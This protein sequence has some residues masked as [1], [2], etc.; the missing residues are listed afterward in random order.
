MKGGPYM[1]AY[2]ST[3]RQDGCNHTIAVPLALLYSYHPMKS[4]WWVTPILELVP[5]DSDVDEAKNVTHEDR[6]QGDRHAK[7]RPVRHF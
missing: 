2:L 1:L 7:I 4:R 5:M 3:L 6:P